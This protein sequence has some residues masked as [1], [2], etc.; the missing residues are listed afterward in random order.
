LVEAGDFESARTI[1]AEGIA[2]NPRVYQL[3]LDYVSIDLK[4]TGLDAALASADRLIAEDQDFA[5]VKPL[6][7]DIYLMANRP[8]DAVTAYVEARKTAPTSLLTTRLSTALLKSGRKDEANKLLAD[9]LSKHPDDLAA[10]EQGAEVNI[11]VNRLDDAARYL[12]RIL[13]DKPH[14]TVALNNL[15]WVYQQKGDN[16]RAQKLAR[17]AYILAPGAQTADTLGW[18]LTTAGDARNGVSLLRQA[19]N[20]ASGDPRITYHYGV[21]LKDTG[22]KEEAKK[23]L[24]L[25]VA[26]QGDF[27]EKAEAQTLLDALSK[28]T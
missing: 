11:A 3:Y 28:G 25:V 2:A 23:Q 12:E 17:Q 5:D 16:V 1:V 9:W 14:D 26:I 20:E 27:K 7:G 6:K 13:A 19:T 10:S 22:D 4:A 15:A 21:A 18:I 8:V 24:E